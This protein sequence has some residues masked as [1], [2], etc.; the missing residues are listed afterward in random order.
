MLRA[1]CLPL[2]VEKG[3]H[4]KPLPIP[5]NERV[6]KMCN[7][8]VVED[9]KHFLL[10]CSLYADLRDCLYK[11]FES[12]EDSFINLNDNDKFVSIMNTGDVITLCLIFKMFTRRLLFLI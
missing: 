11:H 2:E 1:G 4:H 10:T 12:L 7:L 8:G 5:I 3:R 9:E 6:C